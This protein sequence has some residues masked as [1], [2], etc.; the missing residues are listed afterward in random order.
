MDEL[1]SIISQS[2][3]N[4]VIRNALIKCYEVVQNHKRIVCS[5]SGGGDSDV[6]LD[7]L[8]RCGAK[9]KTDFVFFNTGLE[10]QATLEHLDFLE[11]KY[12]IKI[13]REKAIKSIPTSCREHGIPFWSKEFSNN[14]YFMQNH[15]FKYEDDDY[16]TLMQRYPRMKGPIKWWCNEKAEISRFFVIDRAPYMKQFVMEN[17]P[18][19]K[20]S[21]KCCVY[22]KKKVFKHFIKGKNYDLSC[23]GVRKS[24][25]GVR[26][27]AYKNCYSDDGDIH[28]FRPIFWFRDS[29]KEEYCD[30]YNITHSRCYT[31]Y[32][33]KRTGCVGCPYNKNILNELET[34]KKFEPKLYRAAIGV[35][36]KSYEY[37]QAYMEYRNRMKLESKKND[38]S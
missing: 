27:T 23:I 2:P 28:A 3:D 36:G 16:D 7:M 30:F 26:E 5:I 14:F 33:L 17:P 29:D 10:Y 6:M 22:A 35:F 11:R 34:I 37:T 12:D 18:N 19:F 13:L 21:N 9:S 38:I 31:E 1:D 4:F 20:I 32:G 24:E 25:G 8:L 15:D